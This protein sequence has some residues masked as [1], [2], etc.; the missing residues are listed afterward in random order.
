MFP[1][2]T[3]PNEQYRHYNEFRSNA[4]CPIYKRQSTLFC[5]THSRHA[6]AIF[7][8]EYIFVFKYMQKWLNDGVTID[9]CLLHSFIKY[10]FQRSF[11]GFPNVIELNQ[12]LDQN[13]IAKN[14]MMEKIVVVFE[15]CGQAFGRHLDTCIRSQSLLTKGL[16]YFL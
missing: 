11:D 5:S 7:R 12:K 8:M 9:G 16:K 4:K 15:P 6:H 14:S 3:M 2:Q 10:G 13:K 1:F